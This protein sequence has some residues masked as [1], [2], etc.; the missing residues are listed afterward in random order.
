MAM[1]FPPYY[2]NV[3]INGTT[4]QNNH[5]C[6]WSAICTTITTGLYWCFSKTFCQVMIINARKNTTL[7]LKNPGVQ[8]IWAAGKKSKSKCLELMVPDHS[9]KL[10][11]HSRRPLKMLNGINHTTC[12]FS[13]HVQCSFSIPD[14][15]LNVCLVISFLFFIFFNKNRC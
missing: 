2:L 14:S 5:F 4:G 9:R 12:G 11:S 10:I 13:C 6:S 1:F 8:D 3:S 15:C 7:C